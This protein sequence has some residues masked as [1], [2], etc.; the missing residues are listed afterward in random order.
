MNNLFRG[1]SGGERG[2]TPHRNSRKRVSF[3]I[4]AERAVHHQHH[5]EEENNGIA[6][7]LASQRRGTPHP[8]KKLKEQ[9]GSESQSGTRSNRVPLPPPVFDRPTT[10][11]PSGDIPMIDL[12]SEMGAFDD[13]E[14]VC[15]NSML[16]DLCMSFPLR[17]ATEMHCVCL[18]G[19]I[20][21][22]CCV[23]RRRK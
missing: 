23:L 8:T 17:L 1:K 18:M 10:A 6:P 2:G 7:K 11:A 15:H 4:D 22:G 5:H 9:T 20:F 14:K 12:D 16:H 21:V 13:A 19:Q 3:D